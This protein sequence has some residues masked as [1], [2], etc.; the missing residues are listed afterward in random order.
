MYRAEVIVYPRVVVTIETKEAW[1]T[2]ELQRK[3]IDV[4]RNMDSAT[5][6][7]VVQKEGFVDADAY[8]MDYAEIQFIGEY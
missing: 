6:H 1:D 7:N 8:P 4:V 5:L 2:R 3:A